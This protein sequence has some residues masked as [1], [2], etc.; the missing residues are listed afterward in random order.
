MG[1]SSGS[2][3]R[4]MTVVGAR[5][6]FI[7]AAPLSHA[8][9]AAG[10]E[11][12]MVHT[13]QHYDPDMSRVFF[14]ELQIPEPAI[15]LEIGS[16]SHGEQTGRML[17]GI[18]SAIQDHRPDWMLVYGDTNSTLAGALAAAKLHVPVAHVE[19][20]LRSGDRRMPEEVNRIL[21]DHCSDRFFCTAQDAADQ[22]AGEGITDGV[23]VVGDL[24]VDA[25]HAFRPEPNQDSAAPYAL[26]TM[27][28]P[29]NTDHPDRLRTILD[30]LAATG[31]R[32]IW[33]LHPRT[34]HVLE[35]MDLLDRL[36]DFGIEA[37]APQSYVSTQRLLAGADMLVTDSGGMQ[38]E[39]YLAGKPCITLRDTTEW[40]GTTRSGWNVLVDADA[41]AIVDAIAN[42]RPQGE[43]PDLWGRPGA[44]QRIVEQLES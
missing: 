24:M 9:A 12:I 44:A 11:E 19:A 27:H 21:T 6:Q 14:D 40:T 10:H 3:V 13:G 42:H 2:R 17:A 30:A 33:P 39:A 38:K 20:G 37:V 29:G 43:R 36:D 5:P 23:H 31:R 4:I 41:D 7:K 1:A 28:R 15:N 34:R 8:L 35:G 22:L 16:G 26:L 32:F 18:E 25:F